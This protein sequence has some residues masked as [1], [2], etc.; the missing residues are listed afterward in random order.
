MP[1]L[2]AASQRLQAVIGMRNDLPFDLLMGTGQNDAENLVLGL[3]GGLVDLGLRN[4]GLSHDKTGDV[5][6]NESWLRAHIAAGERGGITRG[7]AAG[8]NQPNT[9]FDTDGNGNTNINIQDPATTTH[10]LQNIHDSLNARQPSTCTHQ[11]CATQQRD[12]ARSPHAGK[13]FF[14]LSVNPHTGQGLREYL[15]ARALITGSKKESVGAFH[16]MISRRT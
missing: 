7:H 2:R 1:F 8:S 15:L 6:G 13:T 10:L 12:A 5:D 9:D 3:D 16:F 11:T 4:T 14:P